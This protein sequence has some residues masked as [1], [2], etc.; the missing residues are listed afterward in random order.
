ML[1]YGAICISAD[2]PGSTLNFVPTPE[3]PARQ[4]IESVDAGSA[5]E[6]AGLEAGDFILEVLWSAN[7]MYLF[8]DKI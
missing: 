5:A 7:T 4:Y 8:T 2:P 6:K 3:I 1:L